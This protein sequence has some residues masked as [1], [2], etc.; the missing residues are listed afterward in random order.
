MHLY[1]TLSQESPVIMTKNS[2]FCVASTRA[3]AGHITD[4]LRAASFSNNDISA[5]F[6]T[7]HSCREFVHERSTRAFEGFF[8]GA[9]TSGAIGGVLGWAGFHVLALSGVGF[10]VGALIGA[11]AGGI[12]GGLIGR[13][14]PGG[15]IVRSQGKPQEGD[16]LISVHAESAE[17]ITKAKS[18]FNQA[19]AGD[20]RTT[21]KAPV[22]EP[23]PITEIITYPTES[24]D[25]SQPA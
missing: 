5:L 18:I 9:I 13:R 4:R 7:D 11:V 12:T 23:E 16:I 24:L 17:D 15:G 19:G 6:S 14:M 20:I 22:P 8:T 3:Q 25:V 1:P 2:V 10:I 21:G